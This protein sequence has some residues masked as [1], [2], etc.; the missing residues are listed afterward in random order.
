MTTITLPIATMRD[1]RLSPE[2]RTV[3]AI[4]LSFAP[5]QL[6][7]PLPGYLRGHGI[8]SHRIGRVLRELEALGYM[9]RRRTR[10]GGRLG[11]KWIYAFHAT[12]R[13]MVAA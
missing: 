5:D 8:G 9:E 13:V 3:L 12:P 11:A 2:A 1:E 4:G 6:P 10:A 7:D